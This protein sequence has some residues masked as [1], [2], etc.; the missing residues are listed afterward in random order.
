MNDDLPRQIALLI[1]RS[2]R[3]C[4][5]IGGGAAGTVFRI[6]LDDGSSLIVKQSMGLLREARSL[7]TL[8]SVSRLPLPRVIHASD[9]LLIMSDLG[10]SGRLD[11]AAERHAAELLADLHG[12]TSPD[13]R[14]GLD[15]DNLIGPLDQPNGWMT[16]WL[17]FYR[18]R[19]LF[20]MADA[21]VREGVLPR[22]I[23]DR[24]VAL[25][26]RLADLLPDR[27]AASLIHGDIWGG[28]VIARDGRIAGFIDPAPY[29]AHAEVELAFI[30]MFHTFGSAFFDHYHNL[31]PIDPEFHRARLNVYLLYPLL[32][33]VRI[34]RGGGYISQLESTLTRLGF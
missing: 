29:F 21:A 20:A 24:I 8:A 5:V 31:R 16:S 2:V 15:F 22:R 3:S 30:T 14:F 4:R 23:H 34:Y 6:S 12:V 1:G 28:N 13:G 17:E 27:P 26:R 19:R 9:D 32:T 18:D 11:A 33:H 7:Q 25:A 10:G